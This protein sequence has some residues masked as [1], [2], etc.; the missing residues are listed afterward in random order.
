[1]EHQR[2]GFMLQLKPGGLEA[3]ERLHDQIWP[4]LVAEMAAKGVEQVTIFHADSKLFIYSEIA[5]ARAWE[6][7]WNLDIHLR[8]AAE[9]E[10]YLVL[11][12]DGT[13]ASTDLTEIF[14]LVPANRRAAD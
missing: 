10:P 4:E 13:P 7:L 14:H 1:M 2:A 12:E 6:R 11:A 3:Y 9:L 8:W 5:D